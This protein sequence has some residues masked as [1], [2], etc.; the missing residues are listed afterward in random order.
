[1]R[2][3]S[4]SDSL[5]RYVLRIHLNQASRHDYGLRGLVLRDTIMPTED[6]PIICLVPACGGLVLQGRNH[7]KKSLGDSALNRPY[8]P[9]L[10]GQA[11]G[12][13]GQ[14]RSTGKLQCR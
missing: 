1:M 11:R 4:R 8:N 6:G 3:Y 5:H 10:R 7:Y 14:V 9:D 2:P 13:S 12:V